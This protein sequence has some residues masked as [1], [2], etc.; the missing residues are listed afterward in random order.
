M[1][2]TCPAGFLCFNEG[3]L[4]LLSLICLI[5]ILFVVG[6][7]YSN[8]YY[9]DRQNTRQLNNIQHKQKV[10]EE[11]EK[12]KE[13]T[14]EI[15]NAD[16][17]RKRVTDPLEPP[18]RSHPYGI[19]EVGI[20]RTG[21]RINIP[22]RGYVPNYQQVGALTKENASGDP[23]ILPLYGKPT[24]PGSNKWNYY[25]GTDKFNAVK[26]PVNNSSGENC[27]KEYGCKEIYDGDSVNVPAYGS[28]FNTT[29][30]QLDKP[31][32]IPYL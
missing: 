7:N 26:L 16:I 12:I 9:V 14:R 5:V 32:Y 28:N 23:T 10:I 15:S 13:I 19:K 2:K 21:I 31:R 18:E 24:Y 27:Q 3:T 25:T 20:N 4:L 11:T 6:T 22:T 1:A 30:Y 29:I 17:D 8:I